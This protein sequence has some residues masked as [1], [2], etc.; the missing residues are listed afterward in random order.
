MVYG[1][2]N[3]IAF[4]STLK[5]GHDLLQRRELI[6]VRVLTVEGLLLR[7]IDRSLPGCWATLLKSADTLQVQHFWGR[8]IRFRTSPH[9][10]IQ[11][12]SNCLRLRV[13]S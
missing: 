10:P 1:C 11:D 3:S 8:K 5:G 7:C 4:I 2:F 12:P 13:P 6:I 9:S